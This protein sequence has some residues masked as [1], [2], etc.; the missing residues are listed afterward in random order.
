MLGIKK[1]RLYGLLIFCSALATGLLLF[2]QHAW[3]MDVT[4]A[5]DPN[6]ES[7]VAGYKVYY[8]T[9]AGG[10]Y[11]G[12]SSS[13]GES[14]IVV[15]LNSL[16]NSANP[17]FTVHGLQEVT[18]YFVVTAYNT[19]GLE[20]GYSNE[21]NAQGSSAP[22][23][24][25]SAP[26]L[27]SLEVNET[28]G[29]T[30]VYVNDPSGRV[31]IRIVA[32]DD[33]LVS[34]YLILDGNNNPNGGT[35]TEIPGG[36][37]KNPIF[38]VSDFVLNNSD[39]NHS[40][41]VWV[42]DDQGVISVPSSKTN[43]ILDRV[44]P[45]VV[46]SYSSS[47]PYKSGDSVTITA[48]FTDSN[49]ISGTPT[50]NI[51]YAGTGS[52]VSAA[53][54]TQVSNN[55]WTY[56]MTVPSGNDGSATVTVAAHDAAGNTVGSYAGNAFIVDS[57][58]PT[59]V[60]YPTI[61]YTE[62]SVA[63]TYS[64][65]NMKNATLA[66][67]YSFDNGLL[68]AGNGVD[69]SGT[70]KIFKLPLNPGTLQSYV[71]YSVKIGGAVT[72]SVNNVVTPNT[73]RVNDDDNDGMADDW[74]IRW[75]GSTT[76]KN[77]TADTDG[78]GMTDLREYNAARANPQWG[79]GRWNLSP[80]GKDSDGDGIP[81]KYEIDNGLNPVDPSDRNLD[82]DNDGWTNYQEYVAGYAANN[83]NSPAPTSPQVKEVIPG[84][85]G[86]VPSNSVFAVRLEATQG[87]NIA[88]SS[89]VTVTVNDGTKTYIRNLNDKNA[90]GKGIVQAIPLD[91]GGT[92][93]KNL[94]IAY[95]RANETAMANEFPSGAS[96][97][98]SFQVT[99]ARKDSMTPKTLVFRI[100]TSAE[101]Q[102]EAASLPNTV[103]LENTPVPGLTTSE[104]AGTATMLDGAA[105]I[106]ESAVP[107]NT[108]IIPYLGPTDDIPVLNA[109]GNTGV[110]VPM[111]LL[112]PGL[113]PAAVTLVIPC[114]GY[115][116][117]SGL[118]VYY[119]NGQQWMMACDP[120]GNVQAGGV[121]WMVPGSRVN[122][123]GNP[124]WIEI[125]V[126]H[127]SAVIA[128]TTSG[129]TVVVGTDSGGGG[130]FIDSLMR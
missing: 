117:V 72:D 34:Q 98:V 116:N 21:V 27:S 54:L 6:G 125:K 55:K 2:Q 28:S 73:V 64:E 83:A 63:I 56:K 124:A 37:R 12:S 13:D 57:S 18:N 44:A 43:L 94:W 100:Q 59:V 45:A 84:G 8:G 114:P 31:N 69:T 38:T 3:A 113:F 104:V 92:T 86:P 120:S 81:D 14:P 80:L 22:P 25:N 99:D 61:N 46:I 5:W 105:I 36:P 78:D 19:G 53:A 20:S 101:E 15:P 109:E 112:P 52:D 29:S 95:Y 24:G 76:A 32:S 23:S 62:S 96:V 77:S 66:A 1:P 89:A 107:A 121:G 87:I 17:E 68:L 51:N 118:Y 41:Y 111:N 65:S 82:S 42:K 9:T 108:G 74:E 88:E 79:S 39:G 58:G 67:N 40:I 90:G 130:C 103:T 4:L 123:N 128:A 10:P 122:H 129:T 110:G 47:A 93:S 75:F 119:Y 115:T 50:I 97:T 7:D 126:Y 48:D 127:F 85:N 35:F 102:K 106:Y 91:S 60:G 33:T 49:P 30:P 26:T 16:T 11:R 70:G 71:I